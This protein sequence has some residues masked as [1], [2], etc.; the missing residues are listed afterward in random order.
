MKLLIVEDE[1]HI[2]TFLMKGLGSHGYTVE[3]ITTG[4]EAL[5]RAGLTEF[6]L[7][8]L[9]LGLPDLDGLEVLRQLR[10]GGNSTPI[11][12]VT[13]RDGERARSLELGANDFVTKPFRFDDLLVSV[14]SHV[15]TAENSRARTRHE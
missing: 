14:R 3:H 1:V 9:D 6:S 11:I 8:L 12:I 7:I 13:A 15:D 4:K 2:A 5:T 10:D